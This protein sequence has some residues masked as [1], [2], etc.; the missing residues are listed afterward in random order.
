MT[1]SASMAVATC[2]PLCQFNLE[3]YQPRINRRFHDDVSMP[4]AFFT[5]LL[6][7]AFGLRRRALGLHRAFVP[8]KVSATKVSAAT[9]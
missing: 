5:Q 8:V 6:G 9:A 2:C 1:L 3:C 4:V 7:L